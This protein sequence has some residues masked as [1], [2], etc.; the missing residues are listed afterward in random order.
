MVALI[1]TVLAIVAIRF[2]A[3]GMGDIPTTRRRIRRNERRNRADLRKA[4]RPRSR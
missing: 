4:L 1:M 3:A 2:A